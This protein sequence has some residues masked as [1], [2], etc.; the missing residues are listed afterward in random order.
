MLSNWRTV[1][2]IILTSFDLVPGAKL[3]HIKSRTDTKDSNMWTWCW[4]WRPQTR[5][6]ASHEDITSWLDIPVS[7]WPPGHRQIN[8]W[9][10]VSTWMLI[11]YSGMARD[12]DPTL[13]LQHYSLFTLWRSNFLL[14]IND[15]WCL[16][17]VSAS[18]WF[19][20]FNTTSRH[21]PRDLW[22]WNCPESFCWMVR[23]SL[24]LAIWLGHLALYWGQ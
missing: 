23:T 6:G 10:L 21:W 20:H 17:Q 8:L 24:F 7:S 12:G 9:P 4:H 15:R 19:V 14:R 11:P 13:R 22:I 3:S 2:S 5:H 1:H 16:H 18:L